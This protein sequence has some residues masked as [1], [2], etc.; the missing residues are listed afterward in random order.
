MSVNGL[1]WRL[2]RAAPVLKLPRSLQEILLVIQVR[3]IHAVELH[4]VQVVVDVDASQRHQDGG[5]R[6]PPRTQIWPRTPR[7]DLSCVAGRVICRQG[8]A[9]PRCVLTRGWSAGCR[10]RVLAG[11]S[12]ACGW[13]RF[14]K[15]WLVVPVFSFVLWRVFVSLFAV[16]TNVTTIS[17]VRPSSRFFPGIAGRAY[18]LAVEFTHA[19]GACADRCAVPLSSHTRAIGVAT[20]SLLLLNIIISVPFC[21]QQFTEAALP[22]RD[23]LRT[24]RASDCF[25]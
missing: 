23:A 24:A 19:V 11:A 4:Q 1:I 25:L 6:L 3:H 5:A 20:S 12:T 16:R 8:R 10:K 18:H 14:K 22:K 15:S 21:M 17:N 2:P 13:M 9:S 7:V